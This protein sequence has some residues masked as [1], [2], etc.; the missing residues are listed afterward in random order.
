[1]AARKPLGHGPKSDK[2]W[3]DALRLA[4]TEKGTNGVRKLRA[5]ADRV[6]DAALA[7]DMAAAREIGDRLDGKAHQTSE[8]VVENRHH[9][10]IETPA[11]A[12]TVDEWQ[13]QHG[14]NKLIQ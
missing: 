5:L 7:G 4:V 3:A 11:P 9:Y 14:A 8:A 12:A 6:V 1:M 13:N 2:I 10:V